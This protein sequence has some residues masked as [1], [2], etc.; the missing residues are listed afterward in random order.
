LLREDIIA[1]LKRKGVFADASFFKELVKLPAEAF[2]EFL[3]EIVDDDTKKQVRTTLVKDK[4]IPDTS[5][6][7]IATSLLVELGKKSRR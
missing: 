2:V 7:A 1:R 6:K 4:Q 3:D 5:F